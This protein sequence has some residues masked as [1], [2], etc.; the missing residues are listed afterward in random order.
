LNVKL[1]TIGPGALAQRATI[2]MITCYIYAIIA[3]AIV[4]RGVAG[5]WRVVF[6]IWV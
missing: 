2:P 3:I 5:G 4:C 6:V 1:K